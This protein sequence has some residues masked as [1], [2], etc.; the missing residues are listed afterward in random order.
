MSI[1]YN[2]I[3]DLFLD[4][5]WIENS[6]IS[7]AVLQEGYIIYINQT[8]LNLSEYSRDEIQQEKYAW[9]KIIHPEDLSTVL[10]KINE[11][12]MNKKPIITRYKCRI[13]TKSGKV[14]WIEILSKNTIY[15]GKLAL[16]TT[17][18]E[19]PDPNFTQ[20]ILNDLAQEIRKTIKQDILKDPIY[21]KK[22]FNKLF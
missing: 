4:A 11:K 9:K 15:N 2:E 1:G 16:L 14:K 8:A 3:S 10:D 5:Y 20:K 12:L 22:L 6:L 19:I 7:I 13:I 18:I 21:L 17:L